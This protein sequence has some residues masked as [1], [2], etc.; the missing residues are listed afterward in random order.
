MPKTHANKHAPEHA[1]NQW[2]LIRHHPH[3]SP[4]FWTQFTG[5]FND[6]VFK[7]GLILFLTFSG[8]IADQYLPLANNLGAMLFIL[9]F[10]LCSAF[11]GQLADKMEKSTLIQRVKLLEIILMVAGA[12][13]FWCHSVAALMAVLFLMGL[14]STLFGPVK[15]SLLPQALHPQQLIG[16]NALVEMGT[17]L[18]ILLG[19]V[20]AGL[21]FTSP[22]PIGGISV[23]VVI[24]ALMGW[25]FSRRIPPLSSNDPHLQVDWHLLRQTRVCL[26]FARTERSVFL[27]IL[28][29]SWFWFLGAAYLTQFAQFAKLT[30]AGSPS[31]ATLLMALLA[32]GIGIGSAWCERLSNHK[33]EAGLVPIGAIG[34]TWAGLDL[35]SLDY[36][37]LQ[38]ENA[39]HTIMTLLSTG[40]GL[41]AAIDVLLIGGAGGIYVVPLYALVQQQS[42]EKIRA[43]VIAA[44][45]IINAIAMTASA[46]FSMV[47]LVGLE[48][49]LPHLF[50]I[51]A[52]MNVVVALYIF[53]LVPEF[54]MRFLVW[55][56]THSIYRIRHM[57]LNHIPQEGAAL[58]VSN[59]VT[60]VD[61]LIIA[62]ACRRPVR[63]VVFKPIYDLPILRFIFKIS[64]AIPID[65]RRR[66]PEAYEQAF[67]LIDQL[68]HAGELVCIFPEGKLTLDGEIDEFRP[69]IEKIVN[70]NPTPV[71]PLAL[72]GL[73]GSYF[74]RQQQGVILK[75][76]KKLFA[77][78]DLIAGAPIAPEHASLQRIQN[79]VET[80]LKPNATIID[81]NTET[82]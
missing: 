21:W 11:A 71:V 36:A 55:L 10:F 35:G 41:R 80:L 76:P 34:L 65:S 18:A 16:G 43:R 61:A 67:I 70:T 59:H 66:D 38:T 69:G 8:Q 29:I 79:A 22:F 63:F 64:K 14:Q 74:S 77:R 54:T 78:V 73:W 56:F 2:S 60:F 28:G 82:K 5:A 75:W 37:L 17:F 9:P 3:F 15:Y 53:T 31:I 20:F 47:L 23:S 68:L 40:V 39:P 42:A 19:T 33:V 81:H 72:R 6:N 45:N 1:V 27:S 49:S 48:I 32:V 46:I 52:C 58:L 26:A 51:L 57:N 25:I 50:V 24:I 13:A 44:N 30:L 7:N 62:A 4:F 12:V